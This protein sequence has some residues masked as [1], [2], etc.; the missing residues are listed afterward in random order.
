MGHVVFVGGASKILVRRPEGKRPV[1]RPRHRWEDC[2]RMD[3]KR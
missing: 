1:W 3:C 2:I